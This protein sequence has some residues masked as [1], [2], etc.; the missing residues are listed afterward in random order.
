MWTEARTQDPHTPL[1]YA[2]FQMEAEMP[3]G[4]QQSLAVRNYRY[5]VLHLMSCTAQLDAASGECLDAVGKRRVGG[6]E[7]AITAL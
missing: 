7:R 4:L 1:I 3:P 6:G 2:A 5:A